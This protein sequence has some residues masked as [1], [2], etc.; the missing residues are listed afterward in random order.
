MVDR[1]LYAAALGLAC[2]AILGAVA[3]A[4]PARV[5]D[6]SQAIA[7]DF[8][9]ADPSP[10][11]A[12]TP[13]A[14]FPIWIYS[15][16]ANEFI[17]EYN[18]ERSFAGAARKNADFLENTNN[19]STSSARCGQVGT[20]TNQQACPAAQTPLPGE[21][22]C[23]PVVYFTATFAGRRS[24]CNNY[25]F[26]SRYAATDA[27]WYHYQRPLNGANVAT[28]E[29]YCS[30]AGAQIL[31]PN[32]ADFKNW[33]ETSSESPMNRAPANQVYFRDD[34]YACNAPSTCIASLAGYAS[35]RSIAECADDASALSAD[36]AL[37][38]SLSPRAIYTNSLGG[39]GLGFSNIARVPLEVSTAY[40]PNGNVQG[41]ASEQCLTDSRGVNKSG[42]CI[43]II[44]SCT[45]LLAASAGRCIFANNVAPNSSGLL[46]ARRAALAVLWLAYSAVQPYGSKAWGDVVGFTD[47]GGGGVSANDVDIYPEDDIWPDPRSIYLPSGQRYMR[48][49]SY[50]GSG[51]GSGCRSDTGTSGGIADALIPGSCATSSN[52]KPAGVYAVEFADCKYQWTDGGA[53]VDMGHCA[54]VWNPT[55]SPYMLSAR[56]LHFTYANQLQMN[57][58]ELRNAIGGV[59]RCG[60][61]D[62]TIQS[63]PVSLPVS[64][65]AGDALILVGSTFGPI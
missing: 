19:A 9:A 23:V 13:L 28:N 10:D 1:R 15:G 52:A 50:S 46:G 11:V 47:I 20:P 63:A 51:P 62:G 36:T 41:A 4:K 39:G 6:Q 34:V 17:K 3:C 48:A 44:N 37:N 14:H 30:G 65:P 61:C 8:A 59:L 16:C 24:G 49:L 7:L 55:M 60:N 2:V 31:V 18:P 21:E 45:Q 25:D 22:P 64:I 26:F 58:N 12:A 5:A 27:D 42:G 57:G 35:Q 43:A 29:R 40:K 33:I 38:A 56:T 32:S 54:V 53:K